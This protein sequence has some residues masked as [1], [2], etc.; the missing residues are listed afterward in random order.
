L[1]YNGVWRTFPVG[2]DLRVVPPSWL[3]LFYRP[4][5]ANVC[6]YHGVYR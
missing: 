4:K 6:P 3:Q 2:R 5:V 1:S